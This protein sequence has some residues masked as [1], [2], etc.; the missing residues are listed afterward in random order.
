MLCRSP[1]SKL[2][3]T[4][5]DLLLT[6]CFRGGLGG[7]GVSQGHTEPLPGPHPLS[8]TDLGLAPAAKRLRLSDR[9]A[10]VEEEVIKGDSQKADDASVPDHL[11]L[12]AFVL[13]YGEGGH[14]ARHLRALKLSGG[15]VG[16]LNDPTPPRG[17]RDAL[18]GLRLFALRYWRSRVTRG[19]V[20]WRRA[21]VPLPAGSQLVGYHL[22]R[23]RGTI[24]K[25]LD[26]G[27]RR[28]TSRS[29]R[30]HEPRRRAEPQ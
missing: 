2:L 18:P 9:E 28:A 8:D 14:A 5:A 22:D 11:W 30:W 6:S 13:G 7:S 23:E 4:G 12:R 29:G 26:A 16:C 21:N 25:W 24:Y 27:R 3:H 19:Y 1:P 17:W 15:A 10:A 20:A